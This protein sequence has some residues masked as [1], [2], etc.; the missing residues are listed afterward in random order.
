L[1]SSN[2]TVA[3]HIL[4]LCL[5]GDATD[6]NSLYEKAWYISGNKSS[7]AQ[8]HWALYYYNRKQVRYIFTNYTI[9]VSLA[10][11]NVFKL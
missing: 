2:L 1:K 3:K 6:N 8:K 11:L 4:I 9:L 5:L 7:R 10:S